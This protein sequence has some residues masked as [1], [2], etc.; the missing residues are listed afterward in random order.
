MKATSTLTG[1]IP[2]AVE[3]DDNCQIMHRMLVWLM[4]L[5]L[6][7]DMYGI[8]IRVTH[9][10]RGINKANKCVVF[11]IVLFRQKKMNKLLNN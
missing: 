7:T 11:I 3:K 5:Q 4:V 9:M 6:L 8:H 10:C 1:D 2:T